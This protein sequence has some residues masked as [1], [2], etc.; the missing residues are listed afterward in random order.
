MPERHQVLRDLELDRRL[1]RDGFVVAR[2]ADP[3]RVAELRRTFLE[4]RGRDRE[5]FSIDL[6]I[7]DEPYRRAADA[8]I[9]A[10]L[11]DATTSLFADHQP[12]LRSF[13]SKYPGEGSEMYLH[14]DW[15]YVDERLDRRTYVA[16]VALQDITGDNGQLQV[17]RGSHLLDPSLRGTS[18]ISDIISHEDV[19]RPRLLTVPVRAGEAIVF[20]NAT[21]HAS[22]P[23]HTGEPR[24]AAA[25]GMRPRGAPLVHFRRT[26]DQSAVRYDIDEEFFFRYSPVQ[27]LGAP[28]DLPVAEE[29][30][31]SPRPWTDAELARALD[32][33]YLARIDQA[34]RTVRAGRALLASAPQRAAWGLIRVNDALIRRWGEP[35]S[36]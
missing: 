30:S 9:R 2:V 12:F 27:L 3:D 24:V 32:R 31:L 35:P 34:Q 7:E 33:G 21:F 16:W 15:M 26:D 14:Q 1:R 20:D 4:L 13:L 19:V 36:P 22:Y 11:D 18:L 23:N 5:G 8:A 25:V 10:A 17:L 6:T 28:P 29:I